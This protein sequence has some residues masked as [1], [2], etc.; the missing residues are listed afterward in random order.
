M[1]KNVSPDPK[2][3]LPGGNAT[4]EPAPEN[5]RFTSETASLR[6][7]SKHL[8]RDAVHSKAN[9][10]IAPQLESPM[11]KFCDTVPIKTRHEGQLMSVG[12]EPTKS[13]L[14]DNSSA[15]GSK[16]L[17]RIQGRNNSIIARVR[18][19][20][21]MLSKT[22]TQNDI[23]AMMKR[24]SQNEIILQKSKFKLPGIGHNRQNALTV[25]ANKAMGM[26]LMRNDSQGS[27]NSRRWLRTSAMRSPSIASIPSA[28]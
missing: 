9:L 10:E 27:I 12:F 16:A 20:S 6:M 23:P 8:N 13:L 3:F 26:G 17:A 19:R 7:L 25:T 28:R 4:F 1:Q 21:P 24:L 2:S 18:D 11:Y 22:A 5:Q 15:A 14:R